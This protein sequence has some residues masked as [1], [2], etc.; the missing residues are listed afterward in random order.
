MSVKYRHR[1]LSAA[2]GRPTVAYAEGCCVGGSTEINSAL[3][4]RLPAETVDYWRSTYRIDAF[5]PEILARYADEIEAVLT[6]STMPGAP[7][8]SSELLA[9]GASKLGWRSVEFPRAFRYA[10]GRATKQTMTRT[11]IPAA[12]EAGARIVPD[13]R[14]ERLL[15]DG[16]DVVGAECIRRGPNGHERFRVH[17]RQVFVCGGAVQTPAL[18]LRSGI[19]HCI[20]VGLKMHPMIKIAARF[21]FDLDHGDVPMH[22]ITEFAPEI[23]IGGSASRPGQIAMALADCG[24]AYDEALADWR[25]MGVYYAA[26]RDGQGRVVAVPGLRAPIVTYR[27]TDGDLSRLA[28]GLIYLG[29]ALFAAGAIELYPSVAGAVVARSTRDLGMWRAAVTGAR[30][31]LMTVH[32]ASTVRMGEDHRITGADSFGR[33]RGYANLRVN[34]ASLLPDAPGVNP[35]AT[36]MAIAARNCDQF[37]A[38][39]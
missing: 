23:E 28:S 26:I 12:V 17:A 5:T 31:N 20:G 4:P 25:K 10:D 37:L 35:Q 29:E 14:V 21:P 34:D 16:S 8:L 22:R 36:I 15:R 13:C 30:A 3:F 2:L 11:L 38:T 32:L 6:V 33:V 27:L 1:G 24:A 7:P 39:T 9:T 19:R 18:L